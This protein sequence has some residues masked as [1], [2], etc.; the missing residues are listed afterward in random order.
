MSTKRMFSWSCC[1][2]L[3]LAGSGAALADS[4]SVGASLNKVAPSPDFT[5]SPHA[6]PDATTQTRMR[7]TYARLPLA[8]EA[9]RGQSDPEIKYLARGPGYNL[10]LTETEAVLAL[11]HSQANTA[12]PQ[13]GTDQPTPAASV[14]HMKFLGAKPSPRIDGEEELPGKVNYFQGNDPGQWHT[15]LSTYAKVRYRNVYPGVDLIYYANREQLEYDLVLAPGANP[16]GIRLAFEGADSL[17]LDESGNLVVKL[18][19]QKLVQRAPLVYQVDAGR[20]QKISACYVLA[21]NGEVTIEVGTH[22]NSRSL[23]IDPVLVYSTFL[24]SPSRDSGSGIAVDGAGNAYILGITHSL[25]FPT[26]NPVQPANGGND[27]IFVTKINS[28]GSAIVFSTYLG[29]NDNESSEAGIAVDRAGNVYVTGETR[30]T[31]FPTK[32][33]LQPAL[34]GT[35]GT[36]GN[37]F[38]VKLNATDSTLIYSTYL[39][40]SGETT[41]YGIAADAAGNAYVS[42]N[43]SS[44]DFPTTANVVQPTFNGPYSVYGDGFVAKLSADGS[45]LEYATYLGGTAGDTCSGIAVDAGGEAYVT[46][47]TR[48]VDFPTAHALQPSGHRADAFVTKLDASGSSL[49]YSTYLGGSD[50]QQGTGIA[51]D[52]EGNAY[53]AGYTSSADFPTQNAL[54]PHLNNSVDVFITKLNPAGSALVYSTYLGGSSEDQAGNSHGTVT[55]VAVDLAGNFY[56]AGRTFSTDFPM[57]N[58]IQPVYGGGQLDSYVLKLN[59]EGSALVYSTYLGGSGNDDVS[60][61]AIDDAGN[62]YV[63]GTTQFSADFPVVNALQPAPGGGTASVSDA[64]VAKISD[65]VS[66]PRLRT[67]RDIDGDGLPDLAVLAAGGGQKV[68]VKSQTGHSIS[69]VAFDKAGTPVAFRTL[70]NFGGTPAPELAVLGTGGVAEVRDALSGE[71]LGNVTFDPQLT[72]VDLVVLDDRNGDGVPELA[73]LGENSTGAGSVEVRDAATGTLLTTLAYASVLQPKG[74]VA[75][76]DLTG[77]GRRELGML[78]E[79]VKPTGSDRI[80]V[81]DPVTGLRV[82]NLWQ[83]SGFTMEQARRVGDLTGD[84]IGEVA[85]LRTKPNQVNVLVEDP[86]NAVAVTSLAFASHFRPVDLVS[87]DDFNHNGAFE[88]GLLARNDDTGAQRMDVV[89]SRSRQLLRRLWFPK[90]FVVQAAGVLPDRNGNGAEEVAVLGRRDSDGA[91]NVYIK[92]T[93]SGTLLKRVP[94]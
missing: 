34:K 45:R 4:S 13:R 68:T 40:G 60:G 92:D 59:P 64:F 47:Y 5:V 53:V 17:H 82:V 50:I 36:V 70:D 19:G 69:E 62:A 3:V 28:A 30:S 9:N 14:L 57:R 25:H 31:N 65:T 6:K 21:N 56:L 16:S 51:V 63:T 44:P 11:H 83:G 76:D 67:D 88:V 39:G 32:N 35:K 77:D 73:M 18:G 80:E 85:T 12:D 58:A 48:S 87:I 15:N 72:P 81:R 78:G 46:G 94:F 2:L 66:P 55:N 43:T 61:V 52:R 79:N 84:G 86:V 20:Q 89:D 75:T 8:F 38:V 24:G 1:G 10:F 41:G 23:I 91:M 37:A 71:L 54:Q 7:A 90:D 74:L 33:A 27:D 29:G 22:D 93:A 49:V 42:G 26:V